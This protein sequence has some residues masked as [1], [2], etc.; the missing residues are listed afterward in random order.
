MAA[1]DS[2]R[3][4]PGVPWGDIEGVVLDM[5]GVLWRGETPLPGLSELFRTLETL[6]LGYVLATNNASRRPRDYVER[7]AA[8]GVPVTDAHILTS[9]MAASVDVTSRH[10]VGSTVFVIGE[11]GLTEALVYAGMHVTEEAGA[12]QDVAAVV[13]GYDRGLTYAKLRDAAVLVQRGADFVATN[14]DPSF[15]VEGAV[16]PGAG[17]TVAAL[18]AV[19][20]RTPRVVGKPEPPLFEMAA[21]RLGAPPERLVMVGD[22]L[23]T[24]VAGA[25][26]F[27]LWSVLITTGINSASEAADSP[28]RPHYIAAGLADL[29]SALSA[30][31]SEPLVTSARRGSAYR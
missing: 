22:R 28:W 25:L 11:A 1:A 13:V 16:H 15:P 20:G 26:R 27:G 19:T 10:P 8:F 23:D 12:D 17:A 30:A 24:D 9:A 21:A 31:R 5:D 3:P 6:D 14:A 2:G 7:L 18:V 4:A 29:A